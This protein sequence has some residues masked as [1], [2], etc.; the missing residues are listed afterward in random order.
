MSQIT[1]TATTSE[2]LNELGRR[3]HRYRLQQNRTLAEVART[4]GVS[5]RTA[6]RAE[7]GEN[8]TLETVIRILRALDRLDALDAFLPSPLV[9]PI[10]MA[11]LRGR[12]RRRAGTP[13]RRPR[14]ASKPQD[15]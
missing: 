6:Q 3:L 8:P 12:E 1:P 2:I 14:S 7:A 10:Q 15:G 4:A 9:S 11:K 13:R 5:T